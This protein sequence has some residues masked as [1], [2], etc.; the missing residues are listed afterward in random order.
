[1]KIDIST[2]I[3][4]Q[5]PQIYRDEGQNLI[6]F[7]KAYYEWFEQSDL[8]KSA[9][10]IDLRD[11]D[12][13]IDDF[14]KYFKST[15]LKDLPNITPGNIRSFIKNAGAL[16]DARGTPQAIKLVLRLLYGID[17]EIYLPGDDIF[18][19][20]AG[21]WVVP[22]YL[23]LSISDR[24][25]SF[26][27]KQIRGASSGSSAIVE[28]VVRRF[29]EGYY[30]D[31]VYITNLTGDFIHGEIVT[32]TDEL[33]NAPKIIGSLNSIIITN[34]GRDNNVGDI[35][36]VTSR[37]GK[38]ALA[39]VT[40]VQNATGRVTFELEDG[41]SGYSSN[42]LSIVSSKVLTYSSNTYNSDANVS[43]FYEFEQVE[44]PLVSI[45]FLVANNEFEVGD[46]IQGY[47]SGTW[48]RQANGVVVEVDQSGA[49]GTMTAFVNDGD[50]RFANVIRKS[51][52]TITAN[53][54]EANNIF[55]VANVVGANSIAVGVF[56]IENAFK[57][58]NDQTWIRGLNSN[59]YAN[60]S[61]I[62]TGFGA[63]FNI[64]SLTD[65]ET[66][67][68]Y[69]DFVGSNNI[70]GTPFVD[71]KLTGEG[72]GIGY[73]S[74]VSVVAGGTGY[75]NGTYLTFTGGGQSISSVT[76]VAGGL[77]YANGE[78]IYS[79]TGSN[80]AISL[81][82]NSTGGIVSINIVDGGKA[83][84]GNPIL[85]VNTTAGTGANL[86]A[87]LQNANTAN[88]QISTNSSGGI[89]SITLNDEGSNYY[90]APKITITGGTGANLQ[91]QMQYGYG[92]IK[93]P[94]GNSSTILNSLLRSQSITA[95]TIA[96]LSSISPGQEY[97]QDPFVRV[98][99]PLISSLNRKDII[100]DV[101]NVSGVFT[102]GESL[103]QDVTEAI[104]TINYSDISGNSSFDIGEVIGQNSNSATGIIYERD[105]SQI[106]VKSVSGTF[107]ATSNSA[108]Q[109]VGYTSGASANVSTASVGTNI[110]TVRGTI[111]SANSTSI[112]VRRRSVNQTY[113]INEPVVGSF[114]GAS[115][116]VVGVFQDESTLEM[117]NNAIITANVQ[118]ANGVATELQII[119]SGYGFANGQI[120]D[121]INSENP[122]S[123]T[124]ISILQKQGQGEGFY[125]STDGFL[126]ADKYLHDG[127]YYQTYSYEVQ[128]S[129][130]LDRYA[131]ILKQ[132]THVAGTQMFGR[133]I[134]KSKINMSHEIS[135]SQIISS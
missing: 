85:T 116:N 13:T 75:T 127:L 115:A 46:V 111:K 129:L 112:K 95:G 86:V 89:T 84:V 35:F 20:S 63:D 25:K 45:S 61:A 26:V 10:L 121:L 65:E 101:S 71:I 24:T 91:P 3:E 43:G 113:D 68:V 17:S 41:G 120:V 134:L 40:A 90:T 131:D 28:S 15:Y 5:F 81:T 125:T 79:S 76:I 123:I 1:M 92:F 122:Y 42:A 124:G 132:I 103:V 105:S 64:G 37:T 108:T 22:R 31:V 49:S 47:T 55:A 77:N 48:I 32:D 27:G 78:R 98:V 72:S 39:R 21:Q 133:V 38:N 44:Q 67:F 12:N 118:T 102:P 30:Y 14:V 96:S 51:G 6:A 9:D 69:R 57:I 36:T 74:N 87:V 53:I 88:A 82:T 73:V 33:A 58:Y 100:L 99:D 56:D 16:F 2:L 29:T 34:G 97:N 109:I 107:V 62:S 70:V 18:K 114:S 66:V 94:S 119:D 110:I 54:D 128:T 50:F 80:V 93:Y 52:N 60:I 106:L 104:T 8:I 135:N 130:S 19:L 126:S 83:V 59:T 23:E 117:G 4:T 11:I 7:T